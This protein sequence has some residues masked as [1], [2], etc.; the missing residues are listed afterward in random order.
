MNVRRLSALVEAVGRVRGMSRSRKKAVERKCWIAQ[1]RAWARCLEDP[2]ATDASA[3]DP[4]R[5]RRVA[6]ATYC[7]TLGLHHMLFAT[8]KRPKPTRT[9]RPTTPLGDGLG[10]GFSDAGQCDEPGA[11]GPG[12]YREDQDVEISPAAAAAAVA[13]PAAATTAAAAAA[14]AYRVV[15]ALDAIGPGITSAP[16]FAGDGVGDADLDAVVAEAELEDGYEDADE[17]GN[18]DQDQDADQDEDVDED[19]DEEAVSAADWEGG[20]LCDV[21]S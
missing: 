14:A 11:G 4:A 19:E 9:R 2:A 17:D 8:G 5:D 6:L 18:E 1:S 16:P 3:P 20:C 7:S 13:A 12:E 21:C 10:D 15:P